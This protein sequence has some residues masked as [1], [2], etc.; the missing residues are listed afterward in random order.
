MSYLVLQ[1][2]LCNTELCLYFNVLTPLPTYLFY[3]SDQTR[4]AR[5]AF[6]KDLLPSRVRI[7]LPSTIIMCSL[8]WCTTISLY[9]AHQLVIYLFM[10]FSSLKRLFSL[11]QK[12]CLTHPSLI[13]PSL[14]HH[15]EHFMTLNRD[16]EIKQRSKDK[17]VSFQLMLFAYTTPCLQHIMCLEQWFITRG[18]LTPSGYSAMCE[19]AW[20]V[21]T[22]GK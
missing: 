12:P 22:R 10:N 21:T 16:Q 4:Q 2:C 20:V 7:P 14:F 18:N 13:H 9:L 11:R 15:L 19:G 3:V 17:N 6:F 8:L 5:K 1:C